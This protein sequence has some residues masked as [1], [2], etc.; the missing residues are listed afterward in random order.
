MSKLY[1]QSYSMFKF[2]DAIWNTSVVEV[3]A[4]DQN[5]KSAILKICGNGKTLVKSYGR[6]AAGQIYDNFMW[7]ASMPEIN[8]EEMVRA[9]FIDENLKV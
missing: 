8:F 6:H 9:G 2:A 3:I 4:T 5:G 7:I 1:T